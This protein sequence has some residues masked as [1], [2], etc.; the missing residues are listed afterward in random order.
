M[1]APT[2]T[3]SSPSGTVWAPADGAMEYDATANTTM[4]PAAIA[5]SGGNQP[6][7]NEAPYLVLNFIIALQGIFP[8][9][10]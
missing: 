7:P 3:G 1:A 2:A 6:H 4:K 10:T 8:S 5:N 9:R